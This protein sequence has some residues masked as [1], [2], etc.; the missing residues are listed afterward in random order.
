MLKINTKLDKQVYST[1]ETKTNKVWIDGKPIYRKV[2]KIEGSS[3]TQQTRYNPN[4]TDL[5]QLV[6]AGGT[7]YRKDEKWQILP[8]TYS[9]WEITFYD[10]T[11][12]Q[13][14]INFSGNQW[15]TAK[16]NYVYVIFE[17]TKTTD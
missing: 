6:Y 13:L 9:S 8:D 7:V 4:L 15:G 16:I 12:V 17:Y 3:L 14:S 2:C 11:S 5:D 10:I 1:T